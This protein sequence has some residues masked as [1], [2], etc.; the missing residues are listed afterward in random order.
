MRNER[1]KK[2]GIVR[3][4]KKM[5]NNNSNNKRIH[6]LRE[7]ERNREGE[8]RSILLHISTPSS[9]THEGVKGGG[10]G[11]RC[12]HLR[13]PVR[14]QKRRKRK[15]KKRKRDTHEQ[16]SKRKKKKTSCVSDKQNYRSRETPNSFRLLHLSLFSLSFFFFFKHL[17]CLLLPF[18]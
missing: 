7:R 14:V 15:K 10:G 5:D 11:T 13:P 16:T 9:V 8:R 17:F 4:K 6:R 18:L 1:N 3:E 2:D 12:L